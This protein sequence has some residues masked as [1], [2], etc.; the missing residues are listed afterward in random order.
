[1]LA[2]VPP[3]VESELIGGERILWLG[4]PDPSRHFDRSDL[5]LIPFSLLWGGFAIFWEIAV[6][7]DG[8]GFGMI[9]GIPFVAMGLYFIAG[10]FF[11]KARNKRRTFY[12]VTDRRVLSVKRGGSTQAMFLNAIPTINS[13]VRSDGSG[14]VVFGNNS[15]MQGTYANTGLDFFARGYGGDAVGFYDIR[16]AR[17][18]VSLVNDLRRRAAE[19]VDP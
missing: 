2:N 5:F 13:T 11:V 12:A 3:E 10:R 18:V 15:W 8:W 19:P 7:Q 6:I 9:W 1:M 17:E 4:Q 16:D 14:S